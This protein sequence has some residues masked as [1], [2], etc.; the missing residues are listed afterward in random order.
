MERNGKHIRL[1]ALG[2]EF[3]D[4]RL[5]GFGGFGWAT[6]MLADCFVGHP[7][8]GVD[9]VFFSNRLRQNGVRETCVHDTRLVL[10]GN[11]RAQDWR[12]LRRERL[13]LLLLFDYNLGY[14]FH[15]AALARTPVALW[16]RDPRTLEDWEKIRTLQIPGQE[17][18]PPQGIVPNDCNSVAALARLSRWARRPFLFATPNPA[19]AE[20]MRGAFG[21]ESELLFL[22]NVIRPFPGAPTKSNRPRVV[23]LGRLDPI[24]RPW[25]AVELAR[26][27]PDVE[28]LLLGTAH[29]R[30]AGGWEPRDL[31]PNI[32]AIG[33]ADEEQKWRALASAWVVVNTSIHEGLAV[34]FLEALACETPIVSCVNPAGIVERYGIFVGTW[35]G[36]GLDGVP[37]F[38]AALEKLLRDDVLRARLGKAGRAWVNATHT[39]ARF[40]ESFSALCQRAGVGRQ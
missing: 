33:Q 28:F 18:A 1:G 27:L 35:L 23:F 20:K 29:Y 11:N 3:F 16:A 8:R 24:K 26:R 39:E 40:L 14:R 38:A 6:R 13:D 17:N 4:A 7:E 34:S 36:T 15:C 31:P 10:R 12:N 19:F 9:L 32:Q 21:V 37:S 22:P 2:D 30:G 5:G 25:I